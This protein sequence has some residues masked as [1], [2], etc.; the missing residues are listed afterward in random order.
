MR[1][2]AQFPPSHTR[3]AMALLGPVVVVAEHPAADAVEA[4]SNAG[5]FPVVEA[6]W[7]DARAAIDEIQPSALLLAEPEPP[8]DPRLAQVLSNRIEAMSLLM[9]VL[10]RLADDGVV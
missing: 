5:A 2:I 6:G 9:P 10:A 1:R 8:P 7:A 3:I 4:L